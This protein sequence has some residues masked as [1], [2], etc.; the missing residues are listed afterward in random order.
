MASSE[1]ELADTIDPEPSQDASR[2]ERLAIVLERRLDPLM[3]VLAVLWAGFVTY[4]LVAPPDQRDELSL[5]S[6]IVWGL[7]LTEFVVKMAL[8]GQ[9]L[10]FLRR[11]WPSAVFL[12]LPALRMLRMVRVARLARV[13][14]TARV[15][16]SSY[17]FVGTARGLLQGRL[18]FVGF[19]TFVV[20]LSG[21]QLFY[22]L[23]RSVG[24]GIDSL[25]EAL[26][27]SANLALSSTLV[28]EPATL[29]GRLVSLVLSAYAVLVVAAIAGT[30]GAFFIE[31][32]AE[33][34]AAES[35]DAA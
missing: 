21:G 28:F 16:S 5:I 29:P 19:V 34:A 4:E 6:A 26:W 32:R 10:R 18:T 25:G 20:V 14:P 12:A 31:S 22:L 24:E 35:T 3:A 7:F 2:R 13:L 17:R 15:L 1:R 9:P 33:R 30:V 11:R 27:W 8:A 23:E